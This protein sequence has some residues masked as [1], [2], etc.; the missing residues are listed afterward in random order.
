METACSGE[1]STILRKPFHSAAWIESGVGDRSRSSVEDQVHRVHSIAV[2][3][4]PL[5]SSNNAEKRWSYV[6]EEPIG[7]S[8]VYDDR[9]LIGEVAE[10]VEKYLDVRG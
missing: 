3:G 7:V 6:S 9:Y 5:P 10:V 4:V 1:G 8:H 2:P